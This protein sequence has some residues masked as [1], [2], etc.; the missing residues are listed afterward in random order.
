MTANDIYVWLW[1]KEK[2]IIPAREKCIVYTIH[3]SFFFSFL[4]CF[5]SF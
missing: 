4:Y 3:R 2:D 5:I 1:K